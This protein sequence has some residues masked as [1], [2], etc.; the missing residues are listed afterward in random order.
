VAVFAIAYALFFGGVPSA[1]PTPLPFHGEEYE[2]QSAAEKV[3]QL[4]A[5]IL[6]SRVPGKFFAPQEIGKELISESMNTTFDTPSDEMPKQG[7]GFR[8]KVLHTVG[9]L[10]FGKWVPV[11]NNLGYTGIF[12]E[13]SDTMLLRLSSG[14]D[15]L[16]DDDPTHYHIAAGITL[17]FLKD[18]RP[19]VNIL[20]VHSLPGQTSYNFFAHDFSNHV[21]DFP[22]TASQ[23]QKNSRANFA[24]GSPWPVMLGLSSIAGSET[25]K[26]PRFPYRII[27]HPTT[28]LH[29]SYPDT[30]P[31]VPL[32][33]QLSETVKPGLL[34][35]VHAIPTAMDALNLKAAVHI[36]NIVLT[37]EL[38]TSTFGDSALFFRHVRF[39]EDLKYHPEWEEPAQKVL[40]AQQSMDTQFVYPDLP[41][42]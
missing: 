3:R 19:S 37:T 20:A 28:T 40:E 30:Y 14:F 39:D 18:G 21:S 1:D 8:K 29:K 31:G 32:Y 11:P 41:F 38:T 10:G 26:S 25:L 24:R 42:E 27:F 4:S 15:P 13:G 6:A 34:Y 9:A 36:A 33:Q 2:K 35:T 22:S 23:H 17:K 5:A 16:I 7:D 12:A